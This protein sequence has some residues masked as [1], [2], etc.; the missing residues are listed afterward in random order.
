MPWSSG[1]G[2]WSS[3][4][5]SW[6]GR[7]SDVY[8]WWTPQGTWNDVVSSIRWWGGYASKPGR[9]S[10]GL[11]LL[12]KD[13]AGRFDLCNSGAFDTK[14][15]EIGRQLQASGLGDSVVRLGWEMNGSWF[16]W[17]VPS[18]QKDAYKSCFRRQVD[19]LRSQAPGLL[20]EWDPAKGTSYGYDVR[21]IYPGDA[22][23]DIIGVNYYDAWQA[24]NDEATWNNMYNRTHNGGPYGLGTWLAFAK[25]QGKPLSV[26]E[27]GVCQ[28]CND[29]R[30]RD[31]PLYIRKM[32]EF[33]GANAGSI[34]YETYFNCGTKYNGAS[35]Q[36]Y[37]S[38]SNPLASA[39]YN[40]L[41]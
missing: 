4:F 1:V 33:F 12:T 40:R 28:A 39:E 30:S 2:C 24:M 15:G 22:H 31:N 9:V 19:I 35:Y 5:D 7:P 3:G 6:R 32:H 13:T 18:S 20:I 8:T 10:L 25:G 16:P 14:V 11:S 38:T 21:E 23:V 41:W 17:A 36:I 37:P 34:A 26:P 27:W 29:Q